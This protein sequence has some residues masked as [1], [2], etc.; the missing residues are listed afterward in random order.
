MFLGVGGGV[1]VKSEVLVYIVLINNN[2]VI[3]LKQYDNNVAT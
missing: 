2:V 1:S 3:S